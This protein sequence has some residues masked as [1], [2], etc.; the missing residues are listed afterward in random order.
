MKILVATKLTQ[1][2]RA[3]DFCWVPEGELVKFSI[4]CGRETIDGRCGCKR[5]MVGVKCSKSTTTVKVVKTFM[6]KSTLVNLM[7]DSYV[8]EGWW[9]FKDAKMLEAVGRDVD[10]L[11]KVARAHKVGEVLERRGDKFLVRRKK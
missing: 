5:S 4:P 2:V 11:L 3:N 1:G 9:K 7:A 8:R 6:V 10:V